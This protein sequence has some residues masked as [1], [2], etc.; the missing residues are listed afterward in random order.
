MTTTPF[1]RSA[2]TW[3][4]ESWGNCLQHKLYLEK[5][6]VQVRSP[7]QEILIGQNREQGSFLLLDGQLQ[8]A[9]VDE[10]IYHECLVHP[11]MISHPNPRKVLILGGGEGATLREVLRHP[12]V[13]QVH[14]VEL[15]SLVVELSRQWLPQFS[16]GAF[17][18][19]RTQLILDDVFHYIPNSRESFDVI[20]SD[21]TEPEPDGPAHQLLSSHFLGQLFQLLNPDGI[22]TCQASCGSIGHLQRH[23]FLRQQCQQLL[24]QTHSLIVDIPSFSMDW[25]FLLAGSERLSVQEVDQRLQ[26]RQLASTLRFFDG[27][28]WAHISNLPRPHREALA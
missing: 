26:Q 1:T 22:F 7:W 27:Q 5:L 6:Q 19:P 23:R 16:Q 10:Y 17:D 11:A 3:L 13:E 24:P 28:S 8:S 2:S 15:D 4:E 21:L 20:I 9:E 18:D 12:Q 25:S 14:M